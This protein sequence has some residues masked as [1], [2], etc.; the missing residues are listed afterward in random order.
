M[1]AHKLLLLR[2]FL[3]ASKVVFKIPVYQ[4]N[5]DWKIENCERLLDDIKNIIESKRKHFLGA[6]VFMSS[7][8]AGLSMREFIIIDGQQRLTT[9]TILLK[10]FSDCIKDIDP[11]C[12]DEV[13]TTFLHNKYCPE[14]FKI[15]LKPV[16]GDNDQFL[17]LMKDNFDN[18]E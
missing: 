4:R 18:L 6:I 1:E 2:D 9:M 10:A 7:N 11:E 5:Y 3:G 14:E 13:T 17:S 12:Y 15:K 8:D 16:K